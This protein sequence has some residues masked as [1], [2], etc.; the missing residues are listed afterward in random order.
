MQETC[1]DLRWPVLG[2]GSDGWQSPDPGSEGFISGPGPPVSRKENHDLNEAV[3][4]FCLNH[5]AVGGDVDNPIAH[6]AR[7]VNMS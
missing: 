5:L 7:S 1:M 2:S 4:A 6:H 3:E